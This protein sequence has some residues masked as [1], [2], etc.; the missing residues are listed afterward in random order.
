MPEEEPG[1]DISRRGW[2]MESMALPTSRGS[3]LDYL[4]PLYGLERERDEADG[5]LRYRL[6]EVATR[7]HEELTRT[8]AYKVLRLAGA[9]VGSPGLWGTLI[10]GPDCPGPLAASLRSTPEAVAGQY[11]VMQVLYG[12]SVV[13]YRDDADDG[14]TVPLQSLR[15]GSLDFLAAWVPTTTFAPTRLSRAISPYAIARDPARAADAPLCVFCDEPGRVR[16][17]GFAPE[18]DAC[19]SAWE[20]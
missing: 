4:A 8:A 18:C 7:R 6:F 13:L 11:T 10:L 20:D 14:M 19:A 1:W 17:E 5:T 12:T 15:Y 3:V 9:P 16:A 2:I